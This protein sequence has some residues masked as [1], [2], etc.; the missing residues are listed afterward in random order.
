MAASPVANQKGGFRELILFFFPIALMT[1][2]TAIF[3]FVEK[4]LLARLS[5]V[6]M[7]AAVNAAYLCRYF[8]HLAWPL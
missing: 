8:K 2:S 5:T 3:V 4:L 1:F 6:A 7:E